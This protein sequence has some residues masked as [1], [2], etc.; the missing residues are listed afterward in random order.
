MPA[1]AG[2]R[3]PTVFDS[4]IIEIQPA[5]AAVTVQAGLVVRDGQHFRF[6]SASAAFEPLEGRLFA[7][8]KAA[9]RAA[10]HHLTER[11]RPRLA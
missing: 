4:Y 7:N 8:P 2:G 11:G 6:F 9:Q 3:R 5:L 10:V 1:Q